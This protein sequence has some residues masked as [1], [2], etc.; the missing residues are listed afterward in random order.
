MKKQLLAVLLLIS[1]VFFPARDSH[2]FIPLAV[3][4]AVYGGDAAAGTAGGLIASGSGASGAW[5]AGLVGTAMTMLSIQD[6]TGTNKIQLPL[7]ATPIKAPAAPATAVQS[8][9]LDPAATYTVTDNSASLPHACGGSGL[10]FSAAC[11]ATACVGGWTQ[12]ANNGGSY[13][14]GVNSIVDYTCTYWAGGYTNQKYY[15][16]TSLSCSAGYTVSGSSC[17]LSNAFAVTQDNT[18]SITRSGNSY[19]PIAGDLVGT[20]SGGFATTSASNDTINFSSVSSTGHDQNT[21]VIANSNGTTMSIQTMLVDQ[22]GTNYIQTNTLQYDTTGTVTSAT[23]NNT[24]GSLQPSATNPAV[25]VPVAAPAGSLAP[26]TVP[27]GTITF[28]NDYARTGEATAAANILSPKLDLLHHDL[29][30][31]ATVAD[32]LAVDPATMPSFGTTFDSLK[33]WNL[34]AHVSTCPAPD[35][36]LSGVFGAGHV[37]HFNAHCQLIQDHFAALQAAMMVAWS[38]MAM[39]VVL[40]A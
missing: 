18:Q 17:I 25:L 32:P 15:G 37:Y 6:S 1:L 29:S 22:A 2:A 23:Q 4:A 21:I 13:D 34:P 11:A 7:T 26:Q 27:T 28:P 39:F 3:A 30:D 9:H 38:L 10:S 35:I 16:A 5:L 40:R 20:L 14:A 8:L 31:T 36:D 12:V 33:S 19:S 24:A